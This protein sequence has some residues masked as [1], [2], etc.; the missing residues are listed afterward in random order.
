MYNLGSKAKPA[1]SCCHSQCSKT[2]KTNE[3]HKQKKKKTSDFHVFFFLVKPNHR[4][5]I[6]SVIHITNITLHLSLISCVHEWNS[7]ALWRSNKKRLYSSMHHPSSF[8]PTHSRDYI[9]KT[10]ASGD[11]HETLN[12][13]R[14]QNGHSWVTEIK[15]QWHLPAT[16]RNQ[17]HTNT[18]RVLH[19]EALSMAR[20]CVETDQEM[21]W[22]QT[23]QWESDYSNY[24]LFT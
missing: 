17:T 24:Y 11:R 15:A 7:Q 8:L 12:M 2:K 6:F 20:L 3:K 23:I 21:G 9:S 19:V 22:Y 1:E 18:D 4:R 16:R 13:L 5:G 14:S 10:W